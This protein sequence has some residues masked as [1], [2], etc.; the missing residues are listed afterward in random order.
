MTLQIELYQVFVFL[1]PIFG[2]GLKF[3]VDVQKRQ[4]A[5][6][7][8][9]FALNKHIEKLNEEIRDLYD[10]VSDYHHKTDKTNEKLFDSI[11]QIRVDLQNKANR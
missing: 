7:K 8:E 1:V 4:V 9:I 5:Y 3:Y 11:N 10:I 2:I 6:E